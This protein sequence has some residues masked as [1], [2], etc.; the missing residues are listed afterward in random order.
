MDYVGH[1]PD[2]EYY[3]VKE[4]GVSEH[5]EFLAWYEE[6]KFVVFNNRPMLESYGQDGVTVLRQVCQALRNEFVGIANIVVFQES[7]TIASACNKV[8]RKLF[9]K[10][11]I[12]GLINT[13][14]YTETE[15]TVVRLLCGLYTG[16]RATDATYVT[17]ETGEI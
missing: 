9:L 3:G 14:G 4:M 10:P 8:L 5:T 1:L 15:I 13:G 7:V 11:D 6:Q 2:I 16:N 17:G 12:I